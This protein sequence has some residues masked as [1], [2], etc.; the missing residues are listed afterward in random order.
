MEC[1]IQDLDGPVE[2]LRIFAWVDW[3]GKLRDRLSFSRDDARSP[4]WADLLSRCTERWRRQQWSC[5]LFLMKCEVHGQGNHGVKRE[6]A[7][8][9]SSPPSWFQSTQ[10]HVGSGQTNGETAGET[11]DGIS[12]GLFYSE[13]LFPMGAIKAA[14]DTVP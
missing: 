1:H 13:G 4:E 7:T 9:G 3:Y 11:R 8:G 5:R 12:G 10:C 2:K 14:F 6:K